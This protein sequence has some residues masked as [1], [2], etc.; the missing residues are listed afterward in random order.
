MRAEFVR[1]PC[2][3]DFFKLTNL[4]N[5]MLCSTYVVLIRLLSTIKSPLLAFVFWLQRSPTPRLFS[6][7]SAYSER[8]C[9]CPPHPDVLARFRAEFLKVQGTPE[10][11]SFMS[12]NRIFDAH[13]GRIPGM[14]DGTIYPPTHYETPPTLSKLSRGALERTPLRGSI[15]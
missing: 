2:T 3:S 5:H 7:K 8:P 11:A 13:T 9:F 10:E 12:K 15:R 6:M 1:V 4:L 14:N